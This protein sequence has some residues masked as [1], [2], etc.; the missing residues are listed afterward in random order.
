MDATLDTL[1]KSEVWP[2]V[3]T[4]ASVLLRTWV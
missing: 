3:A 1:H 2:Q 4:A